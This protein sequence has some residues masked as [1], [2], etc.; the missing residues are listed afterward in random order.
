MSKSFDRRKLLEHKFTTKLS[1]KNLNIFIFILLLSSSPLFQLCFGAKIYNNIIVSNDS[2][3]EDALLNSAHESS[4]DDGHHGNN[5]HHSSNN[6]KKSGQLRH[7]AGSG[8]PSSGS[9]DIVLST[10]G[11]KT[12]I[13]VRKSRG[14]SKK[15]SLDSYRKQHHVNHN[16]KNC[17]CG[18]K[19]SVP[20]LVPFCPKNNNMRNNYHQHYD[21]EESSPSDVNHLR[22]MMSPEKTRNKQHNPINPANAREAESNPFPSS[23]VNRRSSSDPKLLVHYDVQQPVNPEEEM[24]NDNNLLMMMMTHSPYPPSVPSVPSFE[25]HASFEDPYLSSP[26]YVQRQQQL[27]QLMHRMMISNERRK[28]Q[29]IES[30]NF[31]QF[32]PKNVMERHHP[33]MFD[34]EE[35]DEDDEDS[36]ASSTNNNNSIKSFSTNSSRN[37]LDIKRSLVD[38]FYVDVHS[39]KRPKTEEFITTTTSSP[40]LTSTS[41]SVSSKVDKK[42][43]FWWK[44]KDDNQSKSPSSSSSLIDEEIKKVFQEN[45]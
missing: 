35:E 39:T 27:L 34:E 7:E 5:P 15:S 9:K 26:F 36:F 17:L 31:K 18:K 40:I 3:E 13:I 19:K 38:D 10:S 37:P 6:N 29:E 42:S 25:H 2:N 8:G 14:S 21:H 20:V 43:S 23:V 33:S 45:K 24:N 16:E 30:R 4:P 12:K 41:I 1:S 22:R 44:S 11:S 32:Y 28:R